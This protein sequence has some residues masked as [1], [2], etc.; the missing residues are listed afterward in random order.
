MCYI[1]NKKGKLQKFYLQLTENQ[2]LIQ[3][4]G[5]GNTKSTIELGDCHAKQRAKEPKPFALIDSEIR[6]A[7]EAGLNLEE[8]K[9]S[10]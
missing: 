3:A 5:S 7:A 2:L 10:E 6:S 4:A 9:T 1:T 8:T